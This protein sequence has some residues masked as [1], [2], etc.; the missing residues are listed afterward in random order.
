MHARLHH[1][2]SVCKE[3]GSGFQSVRGARAGP[4]RCLFPRASSLLP[5]ASGSG[6]QCL[7]QSC[8]KAASC[9]ETPEIVRKAGSD[10]DATGQRLAITLFTL[11][12]SLSEKG[13]FSHSTS[14]CLNTDGVSAGRGPE[15]AWAS[16]QAPAAAGNRSPPW[17]NLAKPL[18]EGASPGGCPWCRSK[19]SHSLGSTALQLAAW[20]QFA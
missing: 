20:T 19:R 17:P 3:E 4:Q 9:L 11:C 16:D 15:K 8:N 14:S 7:R 6:D 5:Y 10:P 1:P 13:V 2:R 18:Q 12:P